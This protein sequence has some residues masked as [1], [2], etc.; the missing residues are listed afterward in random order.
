MEN[1][2][3]E[4]HGRV[5]KWWHFQWWVEIVPESAAVTVVESV[6]KKRDSSDHDPAKVGSWCLPKG[7]AE[8]SLEQI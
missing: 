8:D 5:Y 2:S 7:G 3:S 4:H 6:H 1:Q